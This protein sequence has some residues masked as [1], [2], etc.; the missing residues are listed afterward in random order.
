[1][2]KDNK[3]Q[4]NSDEIFLKNKSRRKDNNKKKNKGSL[5]KVLN[6]FMLVLAVITVSVVGAYCYFKYSEPASTHGNQNNELYDSSIPNQIID[7]KTGEKNPLVSGKY[8]F[9]AVGTDQSQSLTDVMIL[10]TYNVTDKDIALVQI[11]RDTHVRVSS[12]L[13]L[14]GNGSISKENFDSSANR[15]MKINSVYSHAR[16]FFDDIFKSLIN[17]CKDKSV[18]QIEEICSKSCL[19]I[20]AQ[21]I[22]TYLDETNKTQ[23][24][25]MYNSFR[26]SFGMKYVSMLLY[27]NFGVPVDYYAK[28]NTSGFRKIVDAIGGVDVVIQHDMDYEDPTQ[29]LYIHL[30]KGPQHLD[31][32]KAEQFVRFRH[33]YIQADIA[34]MDAQK[35]FI[36]AFIK[37][38]FSLDSISKYDDIVQQIQK[39]LT[40]NLSLQ[41]MLYFATNVLDVDFSKIVMTT[42]PGQSQYIGEVSYYLPGKDAVIETVNTYLNKY[43]NPLTDASFC[44]DDLTNGKVTTNTMTAEGISDKNPSLSFVTHKPSV[45]PPADATL[46]QDNATTDNTESDVNQ[47]TD[48]IEKNDNQQDDIEGTINQNENDQDVPD[49]DTDTGTN[50]GTDFESDVLNDTDDIPTSEDIIREIIQNDIQE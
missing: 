24:N 17:D 14:D 13:L 35:I 38:I 10:A 46:P 1:M 4:N 19:N 20:S 23:K 15:E 21:S 16:K 5:K 2:N 32:K 34:R 22:K 49:T 29:D 40:T 43:Q 36:T 50:T 44:F 28:V 18:S 41:D 37:K 8:S 12:K 25:K 6:I 27:Y 33:G 31:G 48:M 30:K 9:L 39:N 42:L 47:N 45:T 3:Y 7:D 11:P 26:D